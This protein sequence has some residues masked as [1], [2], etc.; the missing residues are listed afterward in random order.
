V[1]YRTSEKQI[2]ISS[3]RRSDAQILAHHERKKR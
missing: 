1:G 2:K 3:R